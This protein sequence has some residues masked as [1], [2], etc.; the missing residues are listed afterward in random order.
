VA[1]L[2]VTL[3]PCL[4]RVLIGRGALLRNRVLRIS[5][6]HFEPGGKGIHAGQAVRLLG[7]DARALY[8]AGGDTGRLLTKC[9]EAEH[10]EPFPVETAAPTRLSFVYLSTEEAGGSWREILE[11]GTRVSGTE[12]KEMMRAFTDLV[13]DAEGVVLSGS[14]PSPATDFLFAEMVREAKKS[15]VPVL[16]DTYGIALREALRRGPA[17]IKV[18]R[19]EWSGAFEDAGAIEDPRQGLAAVFKAGTEAVVVT[20]GKRSVRVYTPSG[21]K[22]MKP[23]KIAERCAVGSGDCMAGAMALARADGWDM[24]PA[25]RFGIAAGAA[26]AVKLSFGGFSRAQVEGFLGQVEEG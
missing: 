24:L 15:K 23:P 17:W 3:S 6:A 8:F 16:L 19:E 7:G 22:V 18:N 25:V 26:N 5:G 1:I 10:L 12:A 4:R 9:V 21:Q 11:E 14:S 20:S 13:P 2:T